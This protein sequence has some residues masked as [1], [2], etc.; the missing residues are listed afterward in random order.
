MDDVSKDQLAELNITPDRDLMIQDLVILAE[1]G[2]SFPVTL[3]TAAGLVSGQVVSYA[4]YLD[5]LERHMKGH[6]AAGDQASLVSEW[7]DSYR[8]VLKPREPN[9]PRPNLIHLKDA[10]VFAGKDV[11]P[12]RETVPWRGKIAS[13]IGIHFGTLRED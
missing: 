5:E 12:S 13:I 7:I 1:Q 2:F 4:Q 8:K 6:G 11:T 10:Q 9:A 3:Y